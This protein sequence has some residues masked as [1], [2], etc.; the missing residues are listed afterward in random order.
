M[1]IRSQK[2]DLLINAILFNIGYAPNLNVGI[3]ANEDLHHFSGNGI[4]IA[5]YKTEE[6]AIEILDEIQEYIES[7]LDNPGNYYV[8]KMPKE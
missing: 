5:E 1:W 2:G 8:Y 7:E 4:R 3:Y 6:R